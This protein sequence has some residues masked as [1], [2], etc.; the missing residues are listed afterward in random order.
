MATIWRQGG[1]PR[2]MD[3]PVQ[4]LYVQE[5]YFLPA[6]TV[7]SWAETTLPRMQTLRNSKQLEKI[8]IVLAEAFRGH[9]IINKILFISH[10]WESKAAPDSQGVQLQAMQEY[11]NEQPNI[12]W[13]WFDY[14]CMPQWGEAEED[15]RTESE[16]A[17]FDVMLAAIGDL[18]LTAHVL[19]LLDNSY[20]S[21]FWTL[22]EAYFAMMKAT[23]NGVRPAP[24][25][26]RRY[27]IMCIHNAKEYVFEAKVGGHVV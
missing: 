24:D 15:G 27:T 1:P 8:P 9:G 4:E 23:P 21:R 14:S 18:Y 10:R 3:A 11:L 20:C 7:K 13:V 17:E 6:T 19:I 12:E 25:A 5:L 26:E 16:Q 22:F 2:E